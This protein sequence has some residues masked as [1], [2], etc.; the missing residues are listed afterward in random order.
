MSRVNK[1]QA[2]PPL[3]P[4]IADFL[5]GSPYAGLVIGD[6][7]ARASLLPEIASLHTRRE[8]ASLRGIGPAAI[9][10]LERWLAH[11]GMRLRQPGEGLDSVIC[12]LSF[13][14]DWLQTL[15]KVRDARTQAYGA[16]ASF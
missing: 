16:V 12:N 11:H 2:P 8:I 6:D 9:A 1:A 14:A 10:N 3:S 5:A 4:L 13:R 15:K 7:A